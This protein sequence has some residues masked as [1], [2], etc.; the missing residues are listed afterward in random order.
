MIFL[1]YNFTT[2]EGEGDLNEK[3]NNVHFWTVVKDGLSD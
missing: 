3:E 2:L 1:P